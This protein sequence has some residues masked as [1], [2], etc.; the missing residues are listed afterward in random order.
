MIKSYLK[1]ELILLVI[2]LI[3]FNSCGNQSVEYDDKLVF[4]YNE[5]KNINSLDPAFAKD[6]SDI[7][8]VNQLFNGLVE[9]DENLNVKPSIAKK[10]NISSDGKKY[11]FNLRQDVYFHQHELIKSRNVVAG[12]FEFSFNRITN[13]SLASPGA[14]IFDNV[15]NYKAINDSTFVINLKKPLISFL[16]ILTMKYCSVVSKEAVEYFGN[17]FRKN[18]IGTGPFKFKKWDE[19]TKLILRKNKIYFEY[20]KKGERLP[21]LE[22]VA[23]S[24]VPE[25]QSEFLEFLQNNIDF[26]SGLDESYKDE[27]L[28]KNGDLTNKYADRINLIRKPYLNTEYLGFYFDS[29]D[30]IINSKLIRKAINHGFDRNKMIKF[31]RNGIGVNANLGFIPYGLPGHSTNE[32]YNYDPDLSKELVKKYILKS[33]VKKPTLNLTTTSN[34]LIFCEYIQKEVEKIG[35]QININV[36]PPSSLKEAKSNGKLDF[37]R[38]SWVADYA[39]AQNYLSLYY[40][41]N[42]SPNGPNYTHFSNKYFDKLYERSLNEMDLNNRILLYKKMD[43]LIMSEHVIVP[44]YYDEVIR[45]THKNINNLGINSINMLDLKKVFKN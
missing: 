15:N 11:T 8:V 4:R 13:K 1:I 31:L 34:Y 33:G 41:K 5:H 32:K 36:V 23:I 30:E 24:F 35:I 25:K 2:I 22:S 7:W 12:D 27:L 28:T 40:S 18:P 10:W 38:A 14:W 9:M 21:H 26:M 43:S 45:F 3:N 39:D 17:D 20:N 6:N 29:T 37:F 44:L 16:G 42:F 19:N